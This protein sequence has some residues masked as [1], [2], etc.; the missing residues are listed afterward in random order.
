MGN[1]LVVN[2]RKN[3]PLRHENSGKSNIRQKLDRRRLETPSSR[4]NSI[5]DRVIEASLIAPTTGNGRFGR[6]PVFEIYNLEF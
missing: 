3:S 6:F 2:I 5:S 1:K 4:Q